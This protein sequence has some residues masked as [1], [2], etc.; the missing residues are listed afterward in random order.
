MGKPT[1]SS[2]KYFMPLTGGA[3]G[4]HTC[5]QPATR[6]MDFHHNGCPRFTSTAYCDDHGQRELKDPKI[7]ERKMK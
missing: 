6:W 4:C 3:I 2:V 5:S 7:T 1:K